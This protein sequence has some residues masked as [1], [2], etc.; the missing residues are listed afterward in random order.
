MQKSI[1]FSQPT[2]RKKATLRL[3]QP[4]R[5]VFARVIVLLLAILAAITP[6]GLC[7]CWLIPQVETVHPHISEEHAKSE[8]PHDYLFQLSQTLSQTN[9]IEIIPLFITPA[10]VWIALAL[11]GSIWW[12]LE[13]HNF[14]EARWR[15]AIPLPPPKN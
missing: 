11:T 3:P 9:S 12:R 13:G 6:P 4:H 7:A 5:V 1:L 8:H 14:Q 15:P 10:T 2:E